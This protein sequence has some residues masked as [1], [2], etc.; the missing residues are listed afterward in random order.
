MTIEEVREDAKR[1]TG[2]VKRMEKITEQFGRIFPPFYMKSSYLYR[3]AY[4]LL[5][6]AEREVPGRILNPG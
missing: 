3:E 4:K 2:E 5:K 1:I 6:E